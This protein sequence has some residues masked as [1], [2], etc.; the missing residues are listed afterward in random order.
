MKNR[1][2]LEMSIST[3]VVLAIAV[4][5][6]IAV[7]S[8]FIGG[9]TESGGTVREISSSADTGISWKDKM[10]GAT[11]IFNKDE[12]AENNGAT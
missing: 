9:F 4:V 3:I 11:D 5:V 1:K 2:G 8:Y 7:V 12:D 10:T 6:M